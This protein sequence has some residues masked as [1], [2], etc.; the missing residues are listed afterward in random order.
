MQPA[1]PLFAFRPQKESALPLGEVDIHFIALASVESSSMT[2]TIC[3]LAK[4]PP[5][6][7][8]TKGLLTGARSAATN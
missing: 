3:T 5:G 4:D 2:P 1:W 8:L 7:H 6:R